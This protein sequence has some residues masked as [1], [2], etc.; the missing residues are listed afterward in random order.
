M[1]WQLA[2][3]NIA[4]PLQPLDTPAL[5]DFVAALQ[6]VNALADASP[7]FVWRLQTEQGDA[8]DIRWAG[9]DEL[10][11]NLS[12]WSSVLALADFVY[13]GEHLAVMRRRKQWFVPLDR[14]VT[15]LWWVTAGHRP[16]VQEAAERLAAFERHG[17]SPY[18]FTFRTAFP[19]PDGAERDRTLP[20]ASAPVD[21][22]G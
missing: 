10:V 16:T 19:A 2:Q 22:P 11:V 9:D 8:T 12:V 18:A 6:P 7:G 4:R 14:A 5:A 3:L 15:V 21:S 1:V 17:P 13:S 20:E